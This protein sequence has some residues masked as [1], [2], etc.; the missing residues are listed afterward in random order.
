MNRNSSAIITLCSHVCVGNDVFPLEP[1]EWNTLAEKLVKME[2]Q[3]S[4]LFDFSDSDFA[5][6][7]N[8]S[9]TYIERIKRLID[10]S[11]SLSFELSRYENMG[12]RVVT[13]ADPDYPHNL[14]KRL[15][16]T[17]PPIFYCAGDMSLLNNKFIGYVGSR[18]ISD[19]DIDFTSKTVAKTVKSGYGVVSGGARGIDTV[20]AE[21]A[22]NS[23]AE[24]IEYLSDSMMKKLKKSAVVRA[25]N[26]SRL[27]MLSA[28]KPDAGFNVGMAMMRNKY[29]YAQS[30]GTI[31]IRT[32]L[33]KGG[34]WAGAVENLKNK[35]CMELCQNKKSY[36]GN[37]ELIKR[38]ALPIDDSWNGEIE[39]FSAPVSDKPCQ[40]E[41]M[42][43]FDDN[44]R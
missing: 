28:A 13:R 33:E 24:V 29:I 40:Y 39:S 44:N 2:L 23:G 1:K 16:N 31:I 32:D 19:E 5:E 41:Q 34:T 15:R 21:T 43:F 42:A 22:L 6:K 14:K 38:G 3:P 37:M 10:R 12:I 30:S 11:A 25:I 9:S 17:C 7:L 8:F 18:S 27:L 26:D 36:R 20:S 35:W 4:D